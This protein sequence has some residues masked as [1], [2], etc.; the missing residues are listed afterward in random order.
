MRNFVYNQS[1][2]NQAALL[3][4]LISW[5]LG[6]DQSENPAHREVYGTLNNQ[7]ITE[8]NTSNQEAQMCKIDNRK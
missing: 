5:S 3:N 6:Q 2:I 8:E 1:L 7:F 4:F